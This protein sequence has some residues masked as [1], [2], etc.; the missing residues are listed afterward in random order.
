MAA[1]AAGAAPELIAAGPI[2]W[3]ILGVAAVGLIGY[4]VYQAVKAADDGFSDQKPSSTE[5]C[6]EKGEST[7]TETTGQKQPSPVGWPGDDPAS[8]PGEGWEWK[9]KG[10]PGSK[11]GNWVGPN[12]ESLHPD[13]DHPDPIGKHWDYKDPSGEWWRIFPDGTMSPK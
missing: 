2:G 3:A 13:L 5:D 9:G 8:S 4:G 7:E 11:E 12:G 6:P 1:V 10:P